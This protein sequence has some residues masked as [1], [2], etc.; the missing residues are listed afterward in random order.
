MWMNE[1]SVSGDG[2]GMWRWRWGYGGGM[3]RGCWDGCV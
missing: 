1:E 3:R 2:L